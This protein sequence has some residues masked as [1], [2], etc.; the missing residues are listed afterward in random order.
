MK[1]NVIN[2]VKELFE[3]ENEIDDEKKVHD[4]NMLMK[5]R[6]ARQE[7]DFFRRKI[8]WKFF[9]K[10]SARVLKNKER[11]EV[12]LPT[13]KNVRNDNYFDA[14]NFAEQAIS[15]DDI[16][17]IEMIVE[18]NFEFRATKYQ[19]IKQIKFKI[20]SEASEAFERFK[21]LA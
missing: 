3:F 7:T 4:E 20:S 19:K 10:Q 8:F 13:I 16:E 11:K 15:V 9:L 6:V 1:I 12:N 17:M 2:I 5:V 18:V 14:M 21:K